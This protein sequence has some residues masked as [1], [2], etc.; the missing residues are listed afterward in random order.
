MALAAL[1]E[2]LNLRLFAPPAAGPRSALAI[3]GWWERRRLAYNAL[4]G[5]AGLVS[6]VGAGSVVLITAL[7]PP[8][9]NAGDFDGAFL[10]LL[11]AL[12]YGLLANVCY[13]G[14]WIAELVL[15]RIAPD[16]STGI[17]PLLF[18]LGLGFSI[19]LT[20]IPGVLGLVALVCSVFA[21]VLSRLAH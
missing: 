12:L 4:V 1:L 15:T 16:R 14:G 18:K 19:L 5:A 3:I 2:Q 13:T 11:F 9:D 6:I 17:G 21:V 8:S 10:G 20:L 7:L